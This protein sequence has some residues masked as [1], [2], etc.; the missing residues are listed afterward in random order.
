MPRFRSPP[1]DLAPRPITPDALATLLTQVCAPP[2]FYVGPGLMLGWTRTSRDEA[3]WEV[4]RGRLLDPA[5]TRQRRTFASWN[6]HA[7]TAEGRSNEPLLSL[8]LDAAAG[9]L[10]VVRG[11]D[12]YVWEGYDSGNNVYLSRERRKWV[13]ELVCTIR[14]DHFSD[15]GDLEDELACALFHAVVGVS[16]LPLS[17]VEAPL[18][19]FSFGGLFYCYRPEAAAGEGPL[20]SW[21]ELATKM[22]G[23]AL[24]WRERARL[25]ETFLHAAPSAE[26]AA[27]ARLWVRRWTDLGGTPATLAALL[28]TLFNEVSLSPWTDLADR[29]LAFLGGLEESGYFDSAEVVDFLAHLLRQI[30]R[31]LTAYD[32][33]TFH[34]RGAN[35]PDALLLDAVLGAYLEVMERCP[36]L[37]AEAAGDKEDI[38]TGKRLRRR[39]L[40]QAYLLRR[41][42]E[43]HPV[44]DLPTSPGESGRVLPASHPRVPEEQILEPSR[45]RRR[46]YAGD[47]LPPRLGP[48][49]RA[50]L[51]QSWEDL[52][53]PAE[54]RELGMGLFIDRPLAAG[55]HPA[56]PDG[57]LLLASAAY[58]RSVAEE[59]LR[60]LAAEVGLDAGAPEV[61]VLRAGL[62]VPGLPLDRI[63]PAARPGSVTLADARRAAP[64]FVFLWTAR[65]SVGALRE[66][67]DFSPLGERLDLNWFDSGRVLVAR[68]AAG[69]GVILYD[70]ALRPRVEL[71]V[72][73][74]K[75]YESRAGQEYP[76]GGLLA[77][78]LWQP[79][80]DSLEEIDLRHAPIRLPP[81]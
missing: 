49:A 54:R 23:P 10:H 50:L 65:G 53:H 5:H 51:R 71:E 35:Y 46:L 8:K 14:L 81:R 64:D 63:G 30:G 31:H 56:E 3:S 36:E 12:S 60:A 73:A 74:A 4:F 34:H 57:T 19:A 6:V 21:E 20:R 13:R 33:V 48:H 59:R 78:R 52:S 38:A 39:A 77:V 37:F 67:F 11:I 1:P 70:D 58:S 7:L 29:T 32:L 40:R 17:S 28:R 26:I 15:L 24:A 18:P 80:G 66:Q 2:H 72:P 62:E 44:P 27:A 42:Y 76:A 41:C 45:R 25:L 69:S 47:P 61:E 43:G 79:A 75:G 68:A 55:K 16:R 9:E 22:L